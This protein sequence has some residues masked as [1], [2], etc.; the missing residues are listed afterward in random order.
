MYEGQYLPNETYNDVFAKMKSTVMSQSP[1]PALKDSIA[2][3]SKGYAIIKFKADNP[4]YWFFHCHFMYHLATGMAVIF[5]ALFKLG[6]ITES[7]NENSYLQ[8]N[9]VTL[10]Q[11]NSANRNSNL[12]AR[13]CVANESPKTCYY[14]LVAE[15]Y[16]TMGPAC[17]NCPTNTADCTA[18]QCVV[19]DGIEKSI[20]TFNRM[21][22]GPS[23]EVCLGDRIVV[24]V[25]N[26]VAGEEL[27]VHWHGIW[28]RG[29]QYMDGVPM[30]TQCPIHEGQTFRYDF[31]ANNPGTHY[32]HTHTGLSKLDGLE[33][34]LIVRN[35]KDSNRNTYTI[36][37]PEH[38]INIMDW[39]NTTAGSRFP[40]LYN[41]QA[42]QLPS[43]F[44]P[45]GQG[46]PKPGTTRA[47]PPPYKEFWVK[48][49]ERYRFRLIGGMCTV[50]GVEVRVE[51]HTML[52]IATDGADINPVTVSSVMLFSGERY[53]VVI[54]AN[55]TGGGTYWMHFRGLAE[56]STPETEI[57]QLAVLRYEGTNQA[58]PTA[59]GYR[60]NFSP[61]GTIANPQN[62]SCG[63]NQ[64]GVC[65]S[66]LQGS[67][68]DTEN[69]LRRNATFNLNFQFGFHI[70]EANRRQD[71]YNNGQYKRYFV[72]P[73]Q[74]TLTSW[75]NNISFVTTPAPILSQ[76]QEVA[77]SIYCPSNTRTGL[78]T[79][80]A[81]TGEDYCECAYVIKIPCGEI[82]QIFLT[83][84]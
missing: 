70:F 11:F 48:R 63:T 76:G 71:L 37:D 3:P 40:G 18:S 51:G 31:I 80:P 65:V 77:S 52:L 72:A 67:V 78:P 68:P 23:I 17:G 32:Y 30:V 55:Q 56:C 60:A 75:M 15:D 39:M 34:T 69:V 20:K 8:P 42:G 19:A 82:V 24:D 83:D 7:F 28:Q 43:T 33:G 45:Q 29:T 22:P 36:D 81:N 41:G 16:V 74:T 57:Y 47:A 53:D 62:A 21:L 54:N 66:Q 14:R 35:P 59:P 79:C 5:K 27:T 4:G 46:R 73:D 49:G 64:G 38:V 12:C 10:A 50:C 1:A 6:Y 2:V 84:A 26:N 44:L 25:T 58:R 9:R 13:N 61:Q